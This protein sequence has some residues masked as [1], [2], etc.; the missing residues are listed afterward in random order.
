MSNVYA[1]KDIK[2]RE[3]SKGTGYQ[4]GS[5]Y[6]EDLEKK[7]YSAL[8][9]KAEINDLSEGLLTKI[10]EYSEQEKRF[11]RISA[12]IKKNIS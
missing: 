10:L 9:S 7:L 3:Y 11:K 1:L 4:L 8:R 5:V 2:D 12:N 6:E